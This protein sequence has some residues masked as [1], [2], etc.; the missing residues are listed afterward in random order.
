MMD[1][2]EKLAQVKCFLLDMDGTFYLGDN[3]IEGS[4]D[5]LDALK[6]TGRQCLF[7]T[8]N[9]SKSGS[10]YEE[11]LKKMNVPEEFR[12]VLTSGQA[13]ANYVVNQYPGKK[14]FLLANEVETKEMMAL[15]VEVDQENPDYVLIAFDTELDYKKMCMLCDHV[16]NGLPYIATHP[17]FNCPT[18]TGFIPD[19]GATIAYVKASTGREPDLIIG[20]PNSGIVEETLRVTGLKKEELAMV[21]DRLYT[22]IA[23]GVNFGMTSILVMSG[24]TTAEMAAESTVK[25]TLTFGRLSDMIPYL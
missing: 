2:R 7:L 16:R 17:D 12:K 5:F 9:S 19:I 14:A 20:K 15:G 22:D 8:N 25:P 3:L 21:G 10:V 6:R 24:E 23:T 11:K 18:E 4:L 1:I 13:A